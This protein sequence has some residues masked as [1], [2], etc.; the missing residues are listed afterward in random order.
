MIDVLYL[1][2]LLFAKYHDFSMEAVSSV[3][4]DA[5]LSIVNFRYTVQL[6]MI[7]RSLRKHGAAALI[8][9]AY[10]LV[11][12]ALIVECYGTNYSS[13][14]L[15]REGDKSFTALDN[16]LVRRFRRATVAPIMM[17]SLISERTIL[18]GDQSAL[19]GGDTAR[20]EKSMRVKINDLTGV[21]SLDRRTR[22]RSV[23]FDYDF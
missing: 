6:Y 22:R 17:D 12:D 23:F 10:F 3:I 19:R 15:T 8:H 7:S 2:L 1:L 4:V 18:R 14:N 21:L 9:P 13:D 20:S 16:R 5:L 11:K